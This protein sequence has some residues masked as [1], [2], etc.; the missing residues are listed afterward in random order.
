MRGEVRALP[1]DAL[2]REVVR[3]I[4]YEAYAAKEGPERARARLENLEQLV[5]AAAEYGEAGGPGLI[6]FLDRVALVSDADVSDG[7]AGVAMMTLHTA[8][9]LE[10]PVVY[11]VGM[12]EGLLPHSRSVDSPSDLEEERRLLYVGMTRAR[13]YLCLTSACVR[14]VFGAETSSDPSRFLD[15]IPSEIVEEM[16][17]GASR[18][19][20]T[21][22]KTKPPCERPCGGS[23]WPEREAA[24]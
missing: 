20:D 12:E 13:E 11:I 2:V 19:T 7:D 22:A 16:R 24:L 15:E 8:K 6:E 14:R 5:T 3:R 17:P 10:F 4:E 23:P 18:Y 1:P 9:G 21:S